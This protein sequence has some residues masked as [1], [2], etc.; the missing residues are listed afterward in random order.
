MADDRTLRNQLLESTIRSPYQW[1]ALAIACLAFL[2]GAGG[3]LRIVDD[4]LWDAATRLRLIFEPSEDGYLY[5]F[6]QETD[7]APEMLFP[8]ARLDGGNNAVRAHVPFE[9]PASPAGDSNS[10]WFVFD[11]TPAHERLTIILAHQPLSGVSVGEALRFAARS[12]PWHPPADVWEHLRSMATRAPVAWTDRTEG[13]AWTE[14]EVRAVQ[15]RSTLSTD[16]PAPATVVGSDHSTAPLV[17]TVELKHRAASAVSTRN[18]SRVTQGPPN[19]VSAAREL[20]RQ[21]RYDAAITKLE[22]VL[23]VEPNQPDALMYMATAHLYSERDFLKANEGFEKSFQAGG[24]AAFWVSHSHETTLSTGDLTDYCRGWLYLRKGEVEFI[25]E[26][27]EH[28]FRLSYSDIKEFK[29]NR[30]APS[31]FHIK[32]GKKNYNF[33]PRTE[34]KSEV[35][36][37]LALSQK[38]PR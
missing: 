34:D 8:D 7:G 4:P 31:M 17:I 27:G 33:R 29:Q 36:L 30:S 24:G 15:S 11:D 28:G 20:I 18:V 35:W 5:I 10:Q 26:D 21:A 32:D 19:A 6:H 16:A 3:W 23:E 25:P 38:F 12:G 9:I 37:I 14:T 2:A 22:Q 13:A 1:L